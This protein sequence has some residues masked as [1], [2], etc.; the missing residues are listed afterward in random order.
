M[1]EPT[2]DKSAQRHRIQSDIIMLDSDLRRNEAKKAALEMELRRL[3]DQK[4]RLDLDIL[5]KEEEI[6]KMAGEQTAL[7]G[8]IRSLRK[9][10]NVL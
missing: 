4:S 3:K 6:R 1:Q 2:Q 7:E 8:E 10:L 5:A 9:K